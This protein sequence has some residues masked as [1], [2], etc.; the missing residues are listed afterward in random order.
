V[1]LITWNPNDKSSGVTLSNNNLTATIVNH[2]NSYLRATEGKTSGKWYW[3]VKIDSINESAALMIGIGNLIAVQ[4]NTL[5]SRT[6]YQLNGNKFPENIAYG[7]NF[8]SV[9]KIVSVLLDIDNGTLEFYVNGVSQG[10]SHTDILSLSTPIFPYLCSGATTTSSSVTSTVNFGATPFNIVTSNPE[11]WNQLL[12]DGY[13]PYD[14]NN[15]DWLLFS[16]IKFQNKFQT[17]LNDIWIEDIQ[18]TD[19]PTQEQFEQYGMLIGN[20]TTETTKVQ[21]AKTKQM[22]ENG[23]EYRWQIN[24]T[25]YNGIKMFEVQ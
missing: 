14:I 24:K 8:A 3:E 9:G 11:V 10:I 23:T 1:S 4:Y 21:L 16:L 7:S 19:P 22:L 20:L 12:A 25:K 5:N 18:I 13:L 2:T 17:L 6:Y 15:A